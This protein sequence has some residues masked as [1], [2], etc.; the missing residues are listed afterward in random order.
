M[1]LV[2]VIIPSY[3]HAQ[4]ISNAIESVLNQTYRDIELIV[5]DDGS[6][7]ESHSIIRTYADEPRVTMILNAEN[8]G[9][10][11]V[12]NRALEIA[13]GK[14]VSF[15]PSDDWYLPRKTEIQVAKFLQCGPE[16]GVVYGGG[17]RFYE[18]TGETRLAILPIFTGNVA[19][20]LIKYGNFVYPAT[21]MFRRECFEVTPLDEEFRAE[22]EAVYI[23]IA[24]NFEFEYVHE[25]VAVMRDHYYNIGKD[26]YIM[27]RENILYWQKFF[28]NK[29]LPKQIRKLR[30]CAL[31]RTHR[32]YGYRFIGE[33]KDFYMARKCLFRA[34]G[35]QP[36][37]FVNCKF[38]AALIVSL[39]PRGIAKR[40]VERFASSHNNTHH[41]AK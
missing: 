23:R 13:R 25:V 22:G 8:R 4:Y 3:N 32:L 1:P 12:L 21:P 41:E 27:Y 36:S 30:R 16:V 10:S 38:L 2:S 17:A 14:F 40:V 9:Q 26:P 28:A 7:D 33:F 11:Y 18:D 5:I 20:K 37:L 35:E 29:L 6:R 24:I 15:L 34:L 19:E 39:L 31:M